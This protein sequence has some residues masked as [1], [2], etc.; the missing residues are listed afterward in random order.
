MKFMK[1]IFFI[2]P[3]LALTNLNANADIT[4]QCHYETAKF[5]VLQPNGQ[6]CGHHIGEVQI[7]AANESEALAQCKMKSPGCEHK[8]KVYNCG[9]SSLSV[10]TGE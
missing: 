4:C 3:F 1:T 10:E 9:F 7:N 5:G 8:T 6:Y 2:F